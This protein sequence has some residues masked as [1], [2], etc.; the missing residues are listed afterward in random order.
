MNVLDINSNLPTFQSP[1][2]DSNIVESA[3]PGERFPLPNAFDTDIGS[4]LV[5]SYKLHATDLDEGLN[6]EIV[7]EFHKQGNDQDVSIFSI[8]PVMGEISIKGSLA[9]KEKALLKSGL[10]TKEK[11]GWKVWNA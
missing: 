6:G 9:M 1:E 5:K 8:N 10:K 7:Y 11:A 2:I 3:F 4:N